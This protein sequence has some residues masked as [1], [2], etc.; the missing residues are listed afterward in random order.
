MIAA[1]GLRL[2]GL[3]LL[4]LPECQLQF[5][6]LLDLLPCLPKL[7]CL[8]LGGA[9]LLSPPTNA[10][11]DPADATDR[12]RWLA[13]PLLTVSLVE[14]THVEE[15]YRDALRALCPAALFLDLVQGD[16]PLW[17]GLG[18]LRLLMGAALGCGAH[19]YGSARSCC[20]VSL[21][22]PACFS[23]TFVFQCLPA[24]YHPSLPMSSRRARHADRGHGRSQ[25]SH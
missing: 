4:A 18:K 17:T 21:Y 10:R 25:L 23:L 11:A 7:R 5:P 8:L 12:A 9:R 16:T 2:R 19:S 20:F 3:K 1:H 22:S 24:Y 14:V 6:S 13:S 15:C